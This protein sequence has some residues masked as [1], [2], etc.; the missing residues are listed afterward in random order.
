MYK[1]RASINWDSGGYI[2]IYLCIL[3][4]KWDNN[5]VWPLRY[6][7]TIELVNQLDEEDNYAISREIT[8]EKLEKFKDCFKKPTTEKN[9]GFGSK[10][11]SHAEIL[12]EK[13]S[14]G[15]GIT[16]RI[17]VEQLPAW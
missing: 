4:G 1:F 17:R 8:K 2:S 7:Y 16:I 6:K 12:K 11:I 10:L 15:N 13:Y 5:L 14:L 9:N 3:K